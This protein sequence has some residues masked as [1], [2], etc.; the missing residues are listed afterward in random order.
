M[1]K[2]DMRKCIMAGK[3]FDDFI[4]EYGSRYA[5]EFTLDIMQRCWDN[6]HNLIDEGAWARYLKNKAA[7]YVKYLT[8]V[9]EGME[10]AGIEL[11]GTRAGAML[12][13]LIKRTIYKNASGLDSR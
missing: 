4:D 10:D 8:L 5:D 6:T 2:N 7:E 12:K 13:I 9:N 3:T 1:L 11:S